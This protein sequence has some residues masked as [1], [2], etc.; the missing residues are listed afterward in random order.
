M[1]NETYK[2]LTS[3]LR[4]RTGIFFKYELMFSLYQS[5]CK[6]GEGFPFSSFQ[7]GRKIKNVTEWSCLEIKERR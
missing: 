1:W 6:R 5:N 7:F 4:E 2:R 3:R